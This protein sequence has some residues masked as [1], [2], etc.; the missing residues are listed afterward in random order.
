MEKVIP[1]KTRLREL[2]NTLEYDELVRM[3][4]DLSKGGDAIRILVDN[5]IKE[6]YKKHDT[7]CTTCSNRVEPEGNTTFTIMFGPESSKKKATF[8]AMDCLEYFMSELKKVTA[9]TIDE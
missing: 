8:C 1:M 6:E 4:N 5:R 9:K 2:I 7:F 3:K